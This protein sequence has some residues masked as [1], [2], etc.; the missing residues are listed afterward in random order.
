MATNP[1]GVPAHIKGYQYLREAILLMAKDPAQSVTKV[2]SMQDVLIGK[3][4][5]KE[6]VNSAG[7]ATENLRVLLKGYND[8]RTQKWSSNHAK[9]QAL[10]YTKAS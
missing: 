1:I 10:Y 4:G 3:G 8:L 6:G 7:V 2:L 9:Y 5:D